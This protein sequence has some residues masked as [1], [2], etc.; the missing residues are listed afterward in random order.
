[1][2]KEKEFV[3]K[4]LDLINKRSRFSSNLYKLN[5][6]ISNLDLGEDLIVEGVA[7]LI[8]TYKKDQTDKKLKFI[9]DDIEWWLY[10]NV[11]KKIY[12]DKDDFVDVN[13]ID[14]YVDYLFSDEC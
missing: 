12:F 6:D 4:C 7:R 3:K 11:D 2:K 13:K 1:M 8:L 10:E 14:D 5:I 9:N